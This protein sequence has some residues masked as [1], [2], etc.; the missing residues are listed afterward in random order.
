MNAHASRAPALRRRNRRLYWIFAGYISLLV[1]LGLHCYLS[2]AD[3]GGRLSGAT[4]SAAVRER[5]EALEQRALFLTF[6]AVNA[7]FVLGAA[8][9]R[10]ID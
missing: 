1:A 10:T 2:V 4:Q 5:T 7:A 8:A 6:I 9:R 3:L